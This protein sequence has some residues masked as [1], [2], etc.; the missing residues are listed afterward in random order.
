MD[1][2]KYIIPEASPTKGLIPIEKIMLAYCMLTLL[3][4]AFL[5]NKIE[6]E[7]LINRTYILIGTALLWKLYSVRPCKFFRL[8][9]IIF[10]VALLGY[11][12]PDIY[13][14]ARF[15][16]NTD[17]FFAGIDQLIFGCQPSIVF[18]QIL[19]GF[20]WNE[21]FN[22]GYFSYYLMIIAIV[23]FSIIKRADKLNFT[24]SMVVCSFM[25][26]YVIF[27][28]LQSSGPQYYF[29]HI[30][31]ENTLKGNFPNVGDWFCYHTELI[32]NSNNNGGLFTHLVQMMQQEEMPIAAFPSSHVGLSTI[33]TILAWK[34]SRKLF[35]VFLPF[36][37]ILCASTVY[38]GAHYAIDV[39]GGFISATIIYF[40]S[41]KIVN[42]LLAH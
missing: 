16:P 34:M 32:H 2:K 42:H 21:L 33:M 35:Y 30:G 25:L 36:Y 18:S 22:M 20:W 12:Y 28:F 3:L 29:Q 26:F 13:H 9:R 4:A 7:P 27:L 8:A 14:F 38:I 6:A 23:L 31:L 37:I 39:L 24:S 17:H 40:I 1:L 11:W 10:Q 15:M 41:L 19:D 5:W